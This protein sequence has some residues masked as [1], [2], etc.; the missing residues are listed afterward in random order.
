MNYWRN[1]T[2]RMGLTEQISPHSLRYAFTQE[3]VD[4]YLK[5]GYSEQE[6]LAK[7][8][9]DLGH[10]DSIEE[11][12]SNWYIELRHNLILITVSISFKT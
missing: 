5:Q 4:Q 1:S 6:A 3:Q 11:G 8:T 12:M 7:A 2:Y 9:M 10:G